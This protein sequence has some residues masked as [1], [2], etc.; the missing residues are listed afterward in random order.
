MDV[1]TLRLDRARQQFQVLLKNAGEI[2]SVDSMRSSLSPGARQ[3]LSSTGQGSFY[4]DASGYSYERRQ[5]DDEESRYIESMRGS[6]LL[7]TRS[8]PATRSPSKG[9]F[10]PPR[11]SADG[12]KG[13]SPHYSAQH[14]RHITISS[15]QKEEKDYKL[16]LQRISRNTDRIS[17]SIL[18]PSG[19][20]TKQQ[21]QVSPTHKTIPPFNVGKAS[22]PIRSGSR[23][24]SPA[25]SPGRAT[26][27]SQR[28]RRSPS[29]REHLA[30]R[31]TLKSAARDAHIRSKS[32]PK[33]RNEINNNTLN[34]TNNSFMSAFSIEESGNNNDDDNLD[35]TKDSILRIKREYRSLHNPKVGSPMTLIDKMIIDEKE[36]YISKLESEVKALKEKNEAIEVEFDLMKTRLDSI[37][38]SGVDTFLFLE[39]KKLTNK[40][41]STNNN[42]EFEQKQL[43]KSLRVIERL[44]IRH[45]EMIRNNYLEKYHRKSVYSNDVGLRCRGGMDLGA[46]IKEAIK[47]NH[48]IRENIPLNLRG[49]KHNNSGFLLSP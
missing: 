47:A 38:T 42:I 10:S 43:Q 12:A 8:P 11:R 30:A 36:N 19:S 33:A 3:Q 37:L 48:L 9:P 2:L 35:K 45:K 20:P 32:P 27:E 18:S 22:S 40:V 5:D 4:G 16:Y 14:D 26:T 44:R 39:N 1:T 41:V 6:S 28:A 15:E 29:P 34:T 21:R 49:H 25:R 31:H 13:S 7:P 24:A 17:K 23:S 46:T